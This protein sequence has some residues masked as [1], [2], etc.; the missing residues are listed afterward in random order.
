MSHT[1]RSET[2]SSHTITSHTSI[3]HACSHLAHSHITQS[4]VSHKVWS[5]TKL[6]LTQPCQVSTHSWPWW[7]H[8]SQSDLTHVQIWH[9][10]VVSS[11]H[12]RW[13]PAQIYQ[14]SP[15]QARSLISY[16]QGPSLTHYSINTWSD[17]TNSQI[18]HIITLISTINIMMMWCLQLIK[19]NINT[20][21][22]CNKCIILW[23]ILHFLNSLPEKN[24]R[25]A[26]KLCALYAQQSTVEN[27]TIDQKCHSFA[28]NWCNWLL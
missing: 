4:L 14:L 16:S 5:Y 15:S 7:W 24:V 3:S 20:V 25:F 28:H 21:V 17:L 19:W 27:L 23:T 8:N 18:F 2:V 26:G 9:I 13:G 22:N 1:V 10:T 12:I 11:C 6:S